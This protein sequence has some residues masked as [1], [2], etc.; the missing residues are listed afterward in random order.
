MT[1]YP[2]II[3]RKSTSGKY[4]WF[5]VVEDCVFTHITGEK[6]I[7]PAGYITDFASVPRFL[8]WFIPPQGRSANASILH[9]FLY[10][11]QIGDRLLVDFFFY[12]ELRKVLPIWQA[13]AMY[14]MVRMFGGSWWKKDKVYEKT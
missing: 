4:D 10:D 13:K 5:E 9:D 6:F 7:I 12:Y 2:D 11:S 1:H 3:L 14:F 8:F